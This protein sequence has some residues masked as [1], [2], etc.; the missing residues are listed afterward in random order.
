MQ[1]QQRFTKLIEAADKAKQQL[2]IPPPS[3]QED[4]N[5]HKWKGM[6]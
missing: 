5:K 4:V 1:R 2:D 3:T 6:M